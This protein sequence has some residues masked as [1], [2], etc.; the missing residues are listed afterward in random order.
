MAQRYPTIPAI[1]RR[2]REN[3]PYENDQQRVSAFFP[4]PM[5]KAF[6]K[7]IGDEGKIRPTDY[8]LGPLY[9]SHRGVPGDL[10]VGVTGG[11]ALQEPAW[12]AAARELGE[13][14]GLVPRSRPELYELYKGSYTS[15]YGNKEMQVYDLYINHAIPVLDHQHGAKIT[16]E[17]DHPSLKVGCFLYGSKQQVVTFLNKTNIYVYY[18][19]DDTVGLGAFK[20]SDIFQLINDGEFEG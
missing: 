12:K 7:G 10:Q 15:Q 2:F 16:Q 4:P 17:K 19:T 1:L 3:A 11:R 18:S 6:L 5:K 14:V 9:K 20:A 13:E 8:I